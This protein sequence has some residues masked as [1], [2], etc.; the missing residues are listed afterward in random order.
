MMIVRARRTNRISLREMPIAPGII[1]YVN[2]PINTE[3]VRA[4]KKEMGSL[5]DNPIGVAES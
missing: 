3:D 2:V 4:F 5:M 1:W